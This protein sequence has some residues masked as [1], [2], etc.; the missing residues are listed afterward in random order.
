MVLSPLTPS[1]PTIRFFSQWDAVSGRIIEILDRVGTQWVAVECF[2]RRQVHNYKTRGEYAEICE[3]TVLITVQEFPYID[4][5]Y[6][7]ILH[8]FYECS[9]N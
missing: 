6:K 3:T 4:S 9:G 7:K 2:E 5:D 1:P 8:E